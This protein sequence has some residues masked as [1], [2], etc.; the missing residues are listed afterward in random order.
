[1]I[2]TGNSELNTAVRNTWRKGLPETDPRFIE[3][4]FRN[5]YKPEYGYA[6]T[7]DGKAVAAVC[8]VPHVLMFNGR[9]L[10]VSTLIGASQLP[11]RRRENRIEKLMDTV[12]DACEHTELIT[13]APYSPEM[14][15]YGF[16]P[17]FRKTEYV[18]TREDIKRITN[19]GCAYDPSP[20]DMLKIYA[21]YIHRFNGFYA[22]EG[23][24][25]IQLKKKVAAK[26]GKVVAYYNAKNQ[27][28]G[29]ATI[30]LQG[31]EAAIDECVYL[32]S[33]ALAKLCN[34]ALQERITVRLRVSE[35]EDLSRLFPNAPVTTFPVMMARLNDS[36]LFSRLLNARAADAEGAFALSEKPVNL[37]EEF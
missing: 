25:F 17:I 14:E 35:A 19:F 6:D 22:R 2:E 28:Q 3:Y 16:A 1:M 5:I 18:L 23:A 26:G 32:N 9:A 13:L 31:N 29:Y 34:A 7:E 15:K 33:M 24:D 4:F 11:E 30:L 27:I 36:E 8:R 12:L 10:K 37:N 21:S 20:L